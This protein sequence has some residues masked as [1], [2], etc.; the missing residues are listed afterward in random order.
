MTS[1]QL[2]AEH[3]SG[4]TPRR[5]GYFNLES[6]LLQLPTPKITWLQKEPAP[7]W[8]ATSLMERSNSCTPT[9]VSL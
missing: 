8:F 2:G 6:C 4:M 1:V 9:V 7:W 5:E 3:V